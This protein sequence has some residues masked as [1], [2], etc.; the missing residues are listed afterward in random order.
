MDKVFKIVEKNFIALPPEEVEANNLVLNQILD[1]IISGMKKVNPLFE[2]L[3]IDK[4]YGG[5]YWDGLKVYKP[6]EYDVHI[7][8]SM[9]AYTD[10]LE[11]SNEPGWVNLKFTR[12]RNPN[13]IPKKRPKPYYG[14][15]G[16]HVL[17]NNEDYLD[18]EKVM[19]WFHQ[20]LSCALGGE[21]K[22]KKRHCK[23]STS[24]G[25]F[26]LSFFRHGPAFTFHASG[27]AEETPVEMDIDFVPCFEFPNDQYPSRGFLPNPYPD[28]G[29]FVVC[30]PVKGSNKG[31]RYW[32][33]SFQ[34]QERELIKGKENLKPALRLMKKMRDKLKHTCIASYFIKNLFLCQIRFQPESFWREPLSNVFITMLVYYQNCIANRSIDFYWYAADNLIS[35]IK[36]EDLENVNNDLLRVISDFQK[37]PNGRNVV[38]KH[39]LTRSELRD[40][41]NIFKD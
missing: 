32:R 13:K 38:A 36:P 34:D 10:R 19:L 25:V 28:K 3:F 23:L 1:T 7:K 11:P 41:K 21:K 17:V 37:H 2:T 5:S 29:I 12:R 31:S 27:T 30:K 20:T 9:S 6:D 4:F 40:F 8:C 22:G 26:N 35:H 33:I 14:I 16:M 39:F 24:H 15:A 18:T